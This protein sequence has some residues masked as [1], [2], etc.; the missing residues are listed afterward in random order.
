M[1][2]VSVV[3]PIF[4]VEDYLPAALESLAGQTHTDLEVVM[5]D[6][7]S[8]DR[9]AEIAA[10]FAERDPRFRLIHQDNHGLGHA[11]NT[12]AGRA[13][14]D[15]L[16]FVDSDDVV[17]H[18]AYRSAVR[19]LEQ[20]GS[21]FL[22][23]NEYRID[24]RGAYPAPMLK[25]NFERT[26]LR[27]TVAARPSLM[28]DLL[29]HNKV[30]RRDFWVGAGLAFPEGILFEDGPVSV[31]AHALA[32]SVDVVS[33]P[34]YYWRSRGGSD[35]S[36]SQLSDD[37]RFYVDRIQASRISAEFLE[38][39]RFD[40]LPAF[41]AWDLRHKF[42][43]MFKALPYAP[44]EV[45]E[46]FM[47]AAAAHL[48]HV[49]DEVVDELPESLARRVRT[50][51]DGDLDHL[52]A[53]LRGR[54]SRRRPA[55]AAPL[56]RA[57]TLA[58]RSYALRTAAA[59]TRRPASPAPVH[60]AVTGLAVRGHFLHLRGY[61][62]V[63]GLPADGPVTGAN[64]LLWVRNLETRRLTR[65][66]VRS[67]PAEQA[68]AGAADGRW[69]Y[70]R[71][72]FDAVL[73]LRALRA[74][75]GRWQ[76]GTWTVAMGVLTPRGIARG[77]LRV[78]PEAHRI[79]PTPIDLDAEARLI[80]EEAGGMLRLR[81][82]RR[83]ALLRAC[84]L[85]GSELVVEGRVRGT[86]STT[87]TVQLSRVPG[88]GELAVEA[89]CR[90]CPDGFSDFSFRLPV[91]A[92]VETFSPAVSPPVSGVQD[93][94]RVEVRP[95]GPGGG[96]YQL[97]CRPDFAG[98][99][100]TEAGHGVVAEPG[101]D[102]Y[103]LVTIRPAMPVVEAAAWTGSGE[104]VL[105]GSGAQHVPALRV[106]GRH[107]GR[108]EERVLPARTYPDGSWQLRVDPDRAAQVAG[109]TA[110][111]AGQWRLVLRTTDRHG[112]ELDTDLP[113]L[114]RVLPA[115]DRHQLDFAGRYRLGRVGLEALA[116][117]VDPRLADGERGPVHG[118][119][120]R[121]AF[122]PTARAELPLRDV[123]LY[124]S[125]NGRQFSDS[126]RAVWEELSRRGVPLEHLWVTRDGQAPVP[127]EVRS[128]EA[129]S[130]EWFEALATS[131]YLV[132]NTHLPPWFRRRPG[133]VVAQTW[134]GIG[135]KR[136]GFDMAAV[137]FANKAYLAN[138]E[139]ETP[140]WS[141]LV[142]PNGFCTP[143]LRRAFRYRGEICEIG[144]PR[145]DL[146]V[147][148]DR[149]AVTTAVRESIGLPPDK[150]IVLY[151]PTWRDNEY[152]GPGLYKF[153]LRLEVASFPEELRQEYALLVRRHPN[154]V[155]DLLGQGSEFVWDVGNYPDPRDL[156]VAADV[157]VTDYSTIALDFANTG[158]PILF[159]AYD[160][161]H[162]RDHL[163]GFYFDLEADGPG[164]VLETSAE[165]A[166]ALRDLDSV[167]EKYRDRYEAVR[168]TF[169]HAEDGRATARLVDRLLRAGPAG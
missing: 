160:L 18:Y 110:L 164:P 143:I 21:D 134:H 79:E 126:P 71:S 91:P 64:R 105:T 116:L 128:V 144:S 51:R 154:T 17:P 57:R 45:Q 13:T 112:R 41:Y 155:D 12:G 58:G 131:R 42:T 23:G 40:L 149:D 157:L 8:T 5:V 36:L 94:L 137:H 167:T 88:V 72:G 152:H 136:V 140:N 35:R 29:P 86:G 67:R 161:A 139:R 70:R 121:E 62:Y 74:P 166:D 69:S 132:V 24:S 96:P 50:T 85:D 60:S 115:A 78:G 106:V 28:R 99:S 89:A 107:G 32:Q 117:R 111:R 93:R 77:G 98:V 44:A 14:G 109:A 165:V 31:Q 26:H 22:S 63:A 151:A 150:K 55:T 9:S 80:P 66:N 37:P 7:G 87:T 123:V 33:L 95:P 43:I 90:P 104:L 1:A 102:G 65:L 82:E 148:G 2:Q 3:L 120:L 97:C 34:M 124:D 122:Y 125:F 103:L 135:F 101:T 114:P 76:Y 38:R 108:R 133:Q 61:G 153:R 48:S 119:V 10:R 163:R 46:Q 169:G 6:D 127:R 84:R 118:R 25:G 92:V 56:R 129:N 168:R 83:D 52:L 147:A 39:H 141:F 142:S 4:S 156:L 15:F 113:F 54:R 159:Y 27:T 100:T 19:T 73:D 16:T 59:F 49:P 145:N 53:Q 81:L 138:L 146:L 20:T 68:T 130:R 162:Y 158:R 75:S 30:Y 47:R 11:R